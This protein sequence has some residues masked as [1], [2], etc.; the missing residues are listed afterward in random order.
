M[1]EP[2]K[3]VDAFD[4]ELTVGDTVAFC[5]TKWQGH[6]RMVKGTVKGLTPKSIHVEVEGRTAPVTI[7]KVKA[8]K[9]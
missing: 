1:S 2:I 3:H 9:L 7:L 8:V 4:T 5:F 6:T